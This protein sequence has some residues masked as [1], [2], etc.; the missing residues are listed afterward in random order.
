MSKRT[1][2]LGSEARDFFSQATAGEKYT[3]FGPLIAY[4][5]G[6]FTYNGWFI[7]FDFGT[8]DEVHLEEFDDFIEAA[9]YASGR[10]ARTRQRIEI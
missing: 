2:L 9:K 3:N 6:V 8:G 7:A 5:G 1:I 10:I 4:H